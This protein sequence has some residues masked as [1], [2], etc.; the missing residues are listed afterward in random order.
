MKIKKSDAL[1]Y[2]SGKRKGKIE[3]VT[4]KPVSTQRDLSLA[5]SPGVAEPCLEIAKDENKVYE[6]TAKGNLV[7]VISNG[8][9]VLGLGDIGPAASKP[10]MEGKGVLFKKFADIDVFDIEL[11]SKNI[12]DLVKAIKMMEPTF[13]G[14]NLEDF[15]GPD[16]FEIERRL[17][18]E[19]NIP[20][21][22]DDQHGTAIISGAAMLNAVELAGKKLSEV[23]AV[24]NGAGASGIACAKFHISLGL[25][26]E[27]VL[28]CDTKGVIHSKRDDLNEYKL[29]F[30]RD[31]DART[32]EDAFVGA[33][34]FFGLSKGNVVTKKMVKSMADNPIIF[35]MANP[36]SEISY[37][38]AI[39]ARKDV[40]MAT[41]RSDYPNQVNN[42]LGFP[43][44]FRG[45]L[46]VHAKSINEE[47]KR[48]AAYSIA[49]LA[50]EEVP[51][52]VKHAYGMQDISYG[53]EYIIPK[54]FDPRVL[55]W[56]APAVAKAAMKSGV[57]RKKITNFEKYKFDLNIR[58]G[59][60]HSFMSTIY[61]KAKSKP[62]RV[63]FPEGENKKIISSASIAL[64]QG[65]CNPVLIG[66]PQYIKELANEINVDLE[67]IEII[68]PKHFAYLNYFAETYYQKR[69][70]KG[71]TK[72]QAL[73]E[74]LNSPNHFGS[75]LLDSGQADAMVSGLT[76]NYPATIRPALEIVGHQDKYNRVSGLYIVI[77][78]NEVYFLTDTT[79]NIDPS[80]RDIS[81]ITLQA[82]EFVRHFE[83]EPRVALLS[84]SNFG[85]ADGD[86]P[87]KMQQ[88]LKIINERA[89]ELIVDGDI[90]AD[91]AV[92]QE[93]IDAEYSFSKLTGGKA[94]VLVFPSLTSGNVSY[95]LLKSLGN[96]NIIG[97]VLQGMSK[98]VHVLQ[99]GSSINEIVDMTAIANV[100]A[101]NLEEDK[102][103]CSVKY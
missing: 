28:M 62:L 53:R 103:V 85:S 15:A 36:V 83:I 93:V 80:A 59:R 49:E 84:Y 14:I 29:E 89:P 8:T 88:A 55:T 12:D 41:G 68:Y 56:V 50:K 40:I 47:M 24:Y 98:S 38:D 18:E 91:V 86:T 51:D 48:A 64:E 70:R 37:P 23:R 76:T 39:A 57:A 21:F 72:Q 32:L 73:E 22:H 95:K 33:D 31:T 7:G 46:D 100:M 4:T 87:R 1:E 94:N 96:L 17:K 82:A 11:D 26:P 35:A 19:M 45:A 102:L 52:A 60:A 99:K 63:V 42:V 9:A 43:F 75:M 79:V 10:V 6:Y 69:Q 25:N 77:S 74:M 92:N 97:P 30:A 58:M 27:N 5:Y 101:Q 78:Q 44:I 3:V 67:G 20:V 34:M 16:C 13:G 61:N 54:P 71:L 66:N 65:I 2:H 81:D 90:Q